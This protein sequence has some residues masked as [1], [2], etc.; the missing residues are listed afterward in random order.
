[1]NRKKIDKLATFFEEIS[2]DTE[3]VFLLFAD[4]CGSTE[5]KA[6]CVQQGQPELLWISRQLIFLQR[7]ADIIKRYGGEVVK[8]IGDEVFAYFH[9]SVNPEGI[10]KSAIEIV[11]SFDG[12][13]SFTGKSKINAKI[14]I[15][16]GS[17]YNGAIIQSTPFDP[18]GVPVDRCARLNSAASAKTIVFSK[19]FLNRL[20]SSTDIAVN[21]QSRYGYKQESADFKGLG[22]T[23]FYRINC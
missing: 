7:A 12:L 22:K 16:F 19:E 15:D 18:I 20:S 14:S 10:L 21:Y 3:E 8:T 13:K 6:D 17:T 1:M 5:Y 11:Q 4:L 9:N 2:G 23:T